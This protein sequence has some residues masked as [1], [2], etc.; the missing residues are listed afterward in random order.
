MNN[1]PTKNW[2]SELMLYFAY[3]SNM[4]HEQMSKRCPNARF[5]CRAY[6]ENHKFVYD[7][8][9][10][11]R[12][13]PV[14]NVVQ[15]NGN[16]VWGGLFEVNKDNLSALDYCEGYP[17]SYNRTDLDIKDDEGI[18]RKAIVYS[19]TGKDLGKPS[20]EYR[21]ITLQGARDCGLPNEYI[22][23]FL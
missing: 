18:I 7:G 1:W 11:T 8:H 16:K 12:K 22:Q 14:A 17:N 9:S 23:S 10:T 5:L 19:R 4:N 21:E 15:E 6:L 13:G 3:G 20:K 2:G